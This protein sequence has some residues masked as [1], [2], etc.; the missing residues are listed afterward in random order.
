MTAGGEGID[1]G[2]GPCHPG[3]DQGRPDPPDPKLSL[4]F[5]E[6]TGGRRAGRAFLRRLEERTDNRDK[7]ISLPSFRAQ[8][9]AVKRWGRGVPSNLSAV[10]QPVPVA[11]GEND[12]TVPSHNTIDLAAHLPRSELVPLYPDSGHGGI[13]STTRSSSQGRLSSSSPELDRMPLE[14][15]AHS[16]G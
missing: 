2:P 9:K 4:F 13:F 12:R 14:R 7:D 8:L 1:K 16:P 15:V 3:H 5:T 6:T 10:R 11:N